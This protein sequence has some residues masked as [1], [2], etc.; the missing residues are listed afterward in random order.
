MIRKDWSLEN[1]ELECDVCVI[2]QLPVHLP[3]KLHEE[4]GGEHFRVTCLR[5]LLDIS[6]SFEAF[7]FGAV[8]VITEAR[9]VDICLLEK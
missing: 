5:V 8:G 4:P 1:F 6:F 2:G 3:L 9:R 7:L